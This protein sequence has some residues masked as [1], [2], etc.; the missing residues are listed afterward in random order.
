MATC[1]L[2]K[3]KEGCILPETEMNVWNTLPSWTGAHLNSQLGERQSRAQPRDQG[4]AYHINGLIMR[5]KCNSS[6]N[7]LE[8]R[9]FCIK[10]LMYTTAWAVW[11]F[12]HFNLCQNI[13][14]TI[15]KICRYNFCEFRVLSIATKYRKTSNISSTLVCNKIVDNSDVVGASIACRR[16]SK[17]IFILNLTPG[18]NGL[19]DDNCKRIQETFKFWDLVELMLEGLRYTVS[20][21]NG[22][23]YSQDTTVLTTAPAA[24]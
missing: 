14:L 23:Y 6:T 9:H 10:Q 1:V 11:Q 19:S 15:T 16:C 13:Q 5:K 20:C 18:F 3:A 7:A 21:Y 24:K 2:G 22:V 17:Y 8:L 4:N 12:S